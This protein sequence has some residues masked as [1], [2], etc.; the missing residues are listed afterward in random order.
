M[1]CYIYIY[2][3]MYICIYIYTHNSKSDI[4]PRLIFRSCGRL[5]PGSFFLLSHI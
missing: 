5:G 3:Y 4:I 2:I 1:T